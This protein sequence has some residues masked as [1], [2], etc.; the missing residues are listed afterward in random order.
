LKNLYLDYPSECGDLYKYSPSFALLFAPF[1]LLPDLPG[2]ILWNLLNALVLFFAIKSLPGFEKNTKSYML[3]FVLIET[4]TSMQNSQSNGL[5]AGLLIFAF[6]FLERDKY[7]LG[8]LFIA[9]T[10]FIKIFGIVAFVFF[11]IYPNKARFFLYSVLW[12]I[13]L[14]ILPLIVVPFDQLKFLYIS[15]GNLLAA[16]HSISYGF[17][18]MGWLN[19]WF[20]FELN[21][22]L[23]VLSGI[24]LFLLP[25]VRYNWYKELKFRLL[26]LASILIWIVIFNHKAESPTFVIAMSGMAIWFFSRKITPVV[27]I[28]ILLAF[29]FGSLTTTDIFPSSVRHTYFYPYVVKAVPSILV[30][31]F[32]SYELLF[33]F[34]KKQIA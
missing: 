20:G 11:L 32:L 4:M 7:A 14:T 10:A 34:G 13:V 33:G 19:T 17:S 28:F 6:V 21:K 18:L 16:D 26:F 1:A 22:N 3:W 23:I 31:F 15:W 9:L 27:L 29:V 2:L 24:I 8:T 25:L 30:W 12:V 5:I